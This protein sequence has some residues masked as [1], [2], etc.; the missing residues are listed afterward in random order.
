MVMSK[1]SAPQVEFSRLVSADQIGPQETEREIVA[2][3]AERARLAERF[4]L[5]AL[6]GLTAVLHLRRSR[7]GLLYL[8]GRIEADVVQPCVVTLE[9]VRSQVAE[10]FAVTFGTSRRSTAND[11]VIAVDEQDPPEELIDGR[12]DLGEAV[13]QQLAVA[14]DPYPRAPEAD[15]VFEPADRARTGEADAASGPFAALGNWRKD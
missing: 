3:A 1:G 5:V 12:I 8:R 6:D 4:G 7:S 14:L 11:V 10:S 13:V 9:P 2:N 15:G